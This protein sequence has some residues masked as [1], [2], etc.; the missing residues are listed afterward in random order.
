HLRDVPAEDRVVRAA[1]ETQPH[2]QMKTDAGSGAE[3]SLYLP[4]FCT[5][6]AALVLILIVELTAF[7]LA[8]ARES[9]HFSPDLARPSLYLLWVGITG[10]AV[11]CLAKKPLARLSVARGSAVV[12]VIIAAVVTFVS[13]CALFIGRMYLI[14]D[15]GLEGLFPHSAGLFLSRNLSIGL[16]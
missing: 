1:A 2:H 4:D 13:S 7:V 3:K 15:L 11:L 14:A 8:L 6:R 5:S 9:P 12:F 16:V 10:A